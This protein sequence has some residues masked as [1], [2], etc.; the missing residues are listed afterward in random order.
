MHI[1]QK[2]S[3]LASGFTLIQD[4]IQTPHG[5]RFAQEPHSQSLGKEGPVGRMDFS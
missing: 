3:S 4:W 1:S 5:S 2:G